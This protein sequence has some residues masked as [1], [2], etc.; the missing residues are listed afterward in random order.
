MNHCQFFSAPVI[1]WVHCGE[2]FYRC[3]I[4]PQI[5]YH[6]LVLVTADV[7]RHRMDDQI[8]DSGTLFGMIFG[9]LALLS[10]FGRPLI[11]E[12]PLMSRYCRLFF[13]KPPLIPGVKPGADCR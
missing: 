8:L 1:G 12:L 5:L 13:C 9:E 2:P 4:G 7:P 6:S 11:G 3:L 10:R